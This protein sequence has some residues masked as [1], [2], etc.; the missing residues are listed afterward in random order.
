M[1]IATWKSGLCNLGTGGLE[2]NM[3]TKKIMG[4]K[5]FGYPKLLQQFVMRK[6]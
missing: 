3:P 2:R 4:S 5:W 6:K 1:A